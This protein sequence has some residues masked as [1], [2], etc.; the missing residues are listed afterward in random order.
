MRPYLQP[1]EWDLIDILT[2]AILSEEG[3][4]PYCRPC[5]EDNPDGTQMCGAAN[6]EALAPEAPQPT[7][8]WTI[9]FLYFAVYI[10][11]STSRFATITAKGGG[12][13][14]QY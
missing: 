10:K 6:V 14:S 12:L 4:V 5:P 1:E 8:S 9:L 2:L 3:K 11:K 7:N 13:I